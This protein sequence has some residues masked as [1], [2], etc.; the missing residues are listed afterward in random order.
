M[1][2]IN[3]RHLIIFNTL[4]GFLLTKM[5]Y[6]INFYHCMKQNPFNKLVTNTFFVF[7]S[8]MSKLIQNSRNTMDTHYTSDIKAVHVM[9]TL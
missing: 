6:D 2:K 8:T 4:L 5:T 9:E 7:E 3:P 1:V